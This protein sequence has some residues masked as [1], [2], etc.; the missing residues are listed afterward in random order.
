MPNK[1]KLLANYSVL[2]GII[3]D[4]Y[5][6]L[7]GKITVVCPILISTLRNLLYITTFVP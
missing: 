6:I 3:K 7:N 1:N 5:I 4:K 2:L